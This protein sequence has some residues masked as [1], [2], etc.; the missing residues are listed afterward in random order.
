MGGD[1]LVDGW[2][3]GWDGWMDGWVD[4]WMDGWMD[5]LPESK[6]CAGDLR[7]HSGEDVATDS[8]PLALVVDFKTTFEG[9][10]AIDQSHPVTFRQRIHT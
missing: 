1:G 2:L 4:G 3:G 6:T 10:C 8:S 9:G 5:G 7:V